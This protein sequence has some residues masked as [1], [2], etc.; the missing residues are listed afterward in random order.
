[1]D[2]LNCDHYNYKKIKKNKEVRIIK[3]NDNIIMLK[4]GGEFADFQN[5]K[6]VIHKKK[7]S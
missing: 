2:E 1:M 7:V 6:Y 5:V 4:A 3:M